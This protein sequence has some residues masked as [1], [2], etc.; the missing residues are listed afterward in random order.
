MINFIKAIKALKDKTPITNVRIS[1]AAV[2]AGIIISIAFLLFFS[3]NPAKAAMDFITGTTASRYYL[4][5][6]LNT[7]VLLIVAGLGASIAIKG[8]NLNLGGEGQIYAG[9]FFVAVILTLPL[10]SYARKFIVPAAFS[11]A[12]A[13]GAFQA[14]LSAL[15]RKFKKANVLLT[16]FLI[17][18]A[19]IP[20]IDSLIAGKFRDK[21]G[22]LLAT[23]FIP[24]NLR[25]APL[26]KPSPLNISI[27][28]APL[29]CL[30]FHY[31]IYR[32]EA[33]RRLRIWG[34]APEFARYCGYSE[35]KS[36]FLSL[37]ASGAM[38]GLAGA[39]AVCGTYF[40]C[41][42]G[43]YAGMGWNAL[44]CA[45]IAQSEPLLLIPA[46]LILSWLYTSSGRVAL[47][48]EIQFDISSLIQGIILFC[49]SFNYVAR[50]RRT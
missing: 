7:A 2:S 26:L 10:P 6:F 20:C 42:S 13:A 28:A 19:V 8:G 18:A 35:E 32:T 47:M 38:H 43:F 30:I 29:L 27:F 11:A 37:A 33:G 40:T 36:M 45:L 50:S 12:C 17:S 48:Q 31:F 21:T 14:I 22:N 15:L 5:S 44:S 4:G 24:E 23:Q 25:L 3:K 1:A 16:S 34:I 41:H 49:I 9:G 46:S 39:I